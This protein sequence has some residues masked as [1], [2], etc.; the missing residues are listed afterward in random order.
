MSIAAKPTMGSDARPLKWMEVW[1]G[2]ERSECAFRVPGIDAWITSEPFGGSIQGGDLQYVSIC[3]AGAISRFAIADIAGHGASVGESAAQLRRLMRKHM[4]IMDQTRFAQTINREFSTRSLSGQFATAL[5]MTYFTSTDH[6]IICNAGHPRPLWYHARTRTW[7]L[8]DYEIPNHA[9]KPLNLPL[10][11]IEPTSYMQFAVALG[12]GDI[13]LTYTDSLVEARSP[14]GLT[15]GE[16]GLLTVVRKLDGS[17]PAKLNRRVLDA[18]AAHRAGNPAEDDQT[19]MV[20]YHSA[21]RA[22]DR[23]GCN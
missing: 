20:L 22:P 6:M 3:G 16:Q 4:N 8:L 15:L 10:G 7:E 13:V 2:N 19:L 11:V 18:A 5:F 21:A 23:H 17:E 1:G 14:R 9:G 12:Q